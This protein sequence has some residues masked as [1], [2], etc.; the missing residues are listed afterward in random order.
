MKR[1][2]AIQII[3]IITILV[4]FQIHPANA[5]R[6]ISV[7][8]KTNSGS[9][10]ELYRNSYALLVGVSNYTGG[11]PDL[12]SVPGELDQVQAA[13]EKHG[14]EVTRI[15]DPQS[16]EL[17]QAFEDFIYQH[18][19]DSGARLLFYFSGHG[20][21]RKKGRK[22]YLVP[23]DA[24]DPRAND[25]GF[26]KKALPMSMILAWAR[27][28]E[29]KHAMFL[30]DSCFSGTIF[31]TRALPTQPPH[32]T[33]LT[34]KP[35][36]QFLTAG[37][38]GEEVPSKSVFTPFFVR[39]LRG[40]ADLN[41]DGYV[42][43]TELGM[44][45][46][47]K[48]MSYNS[49]Q[50]PQY[51]KLRD[52]DF[53][54]GDFVFE[55][56]SAEEPP[57]AALQ[58]PEDSGASFDDLLKASQKQRKAEESWKAWQSARAEEY[59]K[60][61]L[62]DGD[63]YLTPHQKA[64]AWDR[65]LS[66]VSRDNPFSKEDD[67][68]RAYADSRLK[69]WRGGDPPKAPQE[70]PQPPEAVD[71]TNVKKV[72][73]TYS[74]FLPQSHPQ[75]KAAI[76]WAEEV[77][78][79]TGGTLKIKI[80][81]GGT[82]LRADKVYDGVV[83]GIS[84]IGNSCFSYNKDRFPIMQTMDMPMGWKNAVIAS[85]AANEF[86]HRFESTELKDVKLLYVHAHGPGRLHTNTPVKSFEDFKGL[87]IRATRFSAQALNALGASPA[88]L[89]QGETYQAIRAGLIDGTV[90]PME[91][92]K[93][94]RQAEVVKYTTICPA[95]GYTTS[96]Y[97]VMNLKQWG[98]LHPSQQKVL[99]K[100]SAQWPEVHG[101]AWDQSDSE[102]EAFARQKGVSIIRMDLAESMKCQKAIDKLIDNVMS[103]NNGGWKYRN[104]L[105]KK[106][107]SIR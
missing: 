84:D 68:M 17:R 100:V 4:L 7:S 44:Y 10:V 26:A 48:V 57:P 15:L 87:K 105:I 67:E 27:D 30:F 102:A 95:L 42:T 64:Q 93:S 83:S 66:A 23:A 45:L 89:P 75:T 50:S 31:K 78:K 85:K 21:T 24:P 22:G 20:Y 19:Y 59:G 1:S 99:E 11:W 46:H 61:R 69:H 16:H 12:E 33:D 94:W 106:Y 36:R 107:S 13:L 104:S 58:A 41:G 18:G 74:I 103:R 62:I 101:K 96:M 98:S 52:T 8:V 76:A 29:V 5:S 86:A 65:F 80:F 73:L 37:S 47:D 97:V 25:K 32:I 3:V 70:E 39:A 53:D 51:G 90:A 81:S 43:G 88:A 92:L 2:K 28:I 56:P 40:D 82:L 54:E 6:S 77:E 14:F 79:R 9:T 49:L 55:I 91:V 72:N 38:A 63:Q 71:W 34:A 60:A 35:V